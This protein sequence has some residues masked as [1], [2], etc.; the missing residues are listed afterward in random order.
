MKTF[1]G[2]PT[3]ATGC[4]FSADLDQPACGAPPVV[5]MVAEAEGWGL[6][7]LPS[8]LAHAPI[9]RAAANVITEHAWHEICATNDCVAVSDG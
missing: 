3:E 5:H 8:C 2:L 4:A 7:T 6:V 1:V 9:A